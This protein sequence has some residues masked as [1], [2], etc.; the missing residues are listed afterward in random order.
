[1]RYLTTNNLLA[2]SVQMTEDPLSLPTLA[3]SLPQWP[4]IWNMA[5]NT[6][7]MAPREQEMVWPGAEDLQTTARE[8]QVRQAAGNAKDC[9]VCALLSTADTLLP[10]RRQGSLLSTLDRRAWRGVNNINCLPLLAIHIPLVHDHFPLPLF[11][12]SPQSWPVPPPP[13]AP[14]SSLSPCSPSY[15]SSCP[16]SPSFAYPRSRH[17]TAQ[18]GTQ[19][20]GNS[21]RLVAGLADW[22]VLVLELLLPVVPPFGPPV[23]KHTRK[24]KFFLIFKPPS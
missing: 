20:A 14:S 15:F 22:L 3:G 23:E 13:R 6:L 9:G 5:V 1:M 12:N 2:P 4:H 11:L 10:V 24:K 18:M 21:P 7:R 16:C 17:L 8:A 19:A